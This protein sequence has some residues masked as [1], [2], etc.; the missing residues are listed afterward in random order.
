MYTH[1]FKCTMSIIMEGNTSIHTLILFSCKEKKVFKKELKRNRNIRLR[2][3]IRFLE[4]ISGG[5]GI[6]K[7]E[8]EHI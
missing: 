7:V 2:R 5:E 3:L 1:L 4:E 6:I 8:S